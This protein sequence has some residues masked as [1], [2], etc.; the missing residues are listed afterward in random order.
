VNE[1][2]LLIITYYWPPSGGSG[3]QRWLKFVKYL[4]QFG[5]SPYVFTPE[6]PS[7][8][9]KDESLLNDI[10]NEAEVIHFPIWEP[11]SL[12]H[13]AS[14]VAGQS[15]GKPSA[16]VTSGKKSLF[17]RLSI[18]LR[19]NLIIPDP[20]VFWVRPAI[21]FLHDFVR[22]NNIRTVI[23][24]GPPHSIHLIGLGLKKR[25]PSLRWIADFR[26]PWS[27]WGLLD[28]LQVGETA[29]KIHR[30]LEKK[31]LQRSDRVTTITPFYVRKLS[32]LSGRKVDLLTNGFDHED[33]QDFEL[34]KTGK[35]IIRHVG[36]VN[37]K[38]NPRP[39]M[40]AVRELMKQDHT[41]AADARIDFLGEVHPDFRSFVTADTV[42][43]SITTFTP[44]V[45]HQKLMEYYRTS[46]V[47]LIILTGYKDSEGYMP[48]KLFEYIATGTPI[49]GTGPE[50]GD[51]SALLNASGAGKMIEGEDQEKIVEALK[52]LYRN[53]KSGEIQSGRN[54][55]ENY[56]RRGI[57]KQ[58]VELLDTLT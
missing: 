29:R 57:T 34:E 52:S 2:K 8:D 3:V 32:E 22:D 42:L 55:A 45:S 39:F 47:L 44:P 19:G 38:C 30:Y 28:S 56:S 36:I 26:D 53:W 27:T 46:S 48:G 14:R 58:L 54:N 25:N 37:E 21:K 15:G 1:K 20:R 24:T 7:F 17:Q 43:N 10:P 31:V 49:L 12:F 6:N 11:Y 33:F 40:N 13:K 51:A 4:P 50:N 9:L 18:W 35:F 5:Y 41:F 23:T 16:I